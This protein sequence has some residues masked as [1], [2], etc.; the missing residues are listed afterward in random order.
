[1]RP[2]IGEAGGRK[3]AQGDEV[4]IAGEEDGQEEHLGIPGETSIAERGEAGPGGATEGEEETSGDFFSKEIR[5]PLMPTPGKRTEV[6]ANDGGGEAELD[7]ALERQHLKDK[8]DKQGAELE[9]ELTQPGAADA[10]VKDEVKQDG[11]A[12][13]DNL[14]EQPDGDDP[15][16]QPDD[17]GED[18]GHEQHQ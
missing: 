13:G 2:G 9:H 7:A 14:P 10:G 16:C 1:M 12:E 18:G 15:E 17:G 8:E 5:H 6:Q 11:D 3:L 4:E